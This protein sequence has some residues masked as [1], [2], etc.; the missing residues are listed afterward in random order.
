MPATSGPSSQDVP[1]TSGSSTEN[2]PTA[3]GPRIQ[4]DT[5]AHSTLGHSQNTPQ[6]EEDQHT[7][8][9]TD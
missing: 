6:Q 2:V 7:P 9:S 1:L 3:G 5:G 8:S 4:S